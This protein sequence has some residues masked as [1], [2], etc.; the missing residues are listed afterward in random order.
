MAQS[1]S[2]SFPFPGL[3][4]ALIMDGSGRWAVAR[5]LPRAAGHGAGAEAVRRIVARA[6]DCGIGTLTLFAFSE[7]NWERPAA[8]I[9]ALMEVFRN[10]LR[11]ELDTFRGAEIR[12]TVMGRRAR[13]PV[14]LVEAI[15]AA[16]RSTTSARGLHLRLAIDYSARDSILRAARRMNGNPP[17]SR[18]E[19]ARLLAEAEHAGAPAPEIDLL[20]RT[21]GEQRL[22]DC[23]LW[24]GTYAELIF[25]ECLWPDFDARE[26]EAALQEFHSRQRRF[27]SIP[28]SVAV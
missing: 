1:A 21:G 5:G 22:S 7:R 28:E 13:L 20:I 15:Q 19:F 4:V 9:A 16:E 23:L 12:L 27:G 3:H 25:S 18:E 24:E 6:P 14:P 26:L 2:S 17:A 11:A 8:E 10:F